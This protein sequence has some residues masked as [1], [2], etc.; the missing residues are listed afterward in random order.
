MLE[1]RFVGLRVFTWV[2]YFVKSDVFLQ[3]LS[4]DKLDDSINDGY[5][6]PG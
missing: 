6:F 3:S 2:S 4:F 1:M 5:I